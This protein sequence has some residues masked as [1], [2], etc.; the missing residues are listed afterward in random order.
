MDFD[1]KENTDLPDVF[2]VKQEIAAPRIKN[3]IET[4]DQKLDQFNLSSRLHAGQKVAIT[5]GSRGIKDKPKIIKELVGR[6][7]SLGAKPFIVPAMGTH[8]GATAAGQ[9]EVLRS[10]GIDEATMGAPIVSSMDVV[11]IGKTKE[12]VPLLIG[13]DFM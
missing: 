2:H 1:F 11:R 7:K 3:I 4:L 12:G 9:V 5:A 8:G 13:K 10:L 6:F